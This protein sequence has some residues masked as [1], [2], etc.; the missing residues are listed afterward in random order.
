MDANTNM[1]GGRLG[2]DRRTVPAMALAMALAV[3]A[4]TASAQLNADG[5]AGMI[6]IPGRGEAA[7]AGAPNDSSA[8]RSVMAADLGGPQA[9]P[10]PRRTAPPMPQAS[11][12]PMAPEARL[13]MGH[14]TRFVA[15]DAGTRVSADPASAP[16]SATGAAGGPSAANTPEDPALIESAAHTFLEQQ[17][18]GLPGKI[19]ISVATPFARGLAACPTLEPFLPPGARLWGR[20]TVGVRC[21]GEK[22]WTLYLQARL[23]IDATY[24]VSARDIAPGDTLGAA[25]LVA[26]DGDLSV[27]PRSVITDPA[28]ALGSSA[29]GRISAGLPLRQ[30]MLR[31]AAA[32]TAGQTVHVVANGNGF[33]ISTEGSALGNAAPGQP[34]RVK[35]ATGQIVMAVVKDAGTVEVPL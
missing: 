10:L 33:T 18:V 5:Q 8:V 14:P 20:T 15:A 25:D 24:Y 22:P 9:N 31:S 26:R 6:V 7:T 2:R 17:V 19:T 16:T 23:V 29:L 12:L 32:V 35:T 21:A 30:D 1:R 11:K 3:P 27:L 4:G 13:P 28:Q 34:V